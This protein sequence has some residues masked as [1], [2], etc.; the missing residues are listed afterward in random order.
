[1][2][3]APF[4]LKKKTRLVRLLCTGTYKDGL[5]LLVR[6]VCVAIEATVVTVAG[7]R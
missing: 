3:F 2:F 5:E 4:F 7:I 6:M 1:M